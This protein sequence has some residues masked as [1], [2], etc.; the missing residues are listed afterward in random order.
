MT[1]RRFQGILIFVLVAIGFFCGGYYYGKGGYIFEVRKNP[2]RIEVKN[3]YSYNEEVDFSRFWEVWDLVS[4]DYLERPVDAQ[5]MVWGAIGGMVDSLGDPYTTY[6]PP[7]I[8]E[9]VTSGLNG[10]YEGIGAELG[11][12]D[13]Q[14][15]VVAPLDG[16]PA[17]A[18]G[19]LAGDEIVEIAGESTVGIS[20]TEAVAQI[21]GDA[22]TISTLTLQREDKEPFVVHIKRGK[23]TID[24]V[25]WADKEDGTAYI[26]VS[27]FGEDT[28]KNWS[29]VAA[30]VN[31]QMGELDAIIL[32]LRGNPGGWM[33]RAAFIADEFIKGKEVVLYQESALG[34]LLP[35]YTSRVGAFENL[36][37]VF[38][39]IDE[40]S[41]SASEILAAALDAHIE[42][43]VLVG[44]KSFGKGTIQDAK[45][46]SD[47]AGVH[48]TVAKWLTPN[49]VWVHKEGIEPEVVVERVPEDMENGIDAQLDKAIELAKE[50]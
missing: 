19:V 31:V 50:F 42:D 22:G 10:T 48:I 28:N 7:E 46:F 5:K 33:D 9:R 36:P 6:L 47:G 18:A 26:R 1:F 12:K 43:V 23:I 21:R 37:A 40:G 11:L 17:K 30:E 41:A 16:S 25:T 35:F 20:V 29:K 45:E 8:N 24:S 13:N 34:E 15:I 3:K 39:L 49:E 4:R 27:T 44:T 32:D 38:V 14:L 2:P